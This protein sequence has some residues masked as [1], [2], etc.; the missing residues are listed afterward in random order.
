MLNGKTAGYRIDQRYRFG[1]C[2]K[3]GCSGANVIL[4][5]FGD[6]DAP[7]QSWLPAKPRREKWVTTAPT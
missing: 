6:V 2:R 4:N 5:G 7:S 3:A 1:H